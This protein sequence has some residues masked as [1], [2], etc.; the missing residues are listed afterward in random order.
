MPI[1]GLDLATLSLLDALDLAILIEDEAR[2]RYEEFAAQ[3]DQH[4]T[5]EAARFFRYS[6]EHYLLEPY[7]VCKEYQPYRDGCYLMNLSAL[8]QAALFGF[9]STSSRSEVFG[10]RCA[11]EAL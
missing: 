9:D 8:L 3:M 6:W 4:R 7:G 2:E 5:P 11:K 10:F 1:R